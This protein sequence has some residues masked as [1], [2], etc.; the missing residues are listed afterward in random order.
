MD[1]QIAAC[2]HRLS[3]KELAKHF[4]PP[5]KANRLS[6]QPH[7]QTASTTRGEESICACSAQLRFKRGWYLITSVRPEHHS[8]TLHQHV[9]I[10]NHFPRIPSANHSITDIKPIRKV[11]KIELPIVQLSPR[12]SLLVDLLHDLHLSNEDGKR[13]VFQAKIH[14]YNGDANISKK[15]AVD[16]IDIGVEVVGWAACDHNVVHVTKRALSHL[17]QLDEGGESRIW[18]TEINVSHALVVVQL[19]K[20]DGIGDVGVIIFYSWWTTYMSYDWLKQFQ[21]LLRC[22]YRFRAK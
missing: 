9:R 13:L 16:G 7:L 10:T 22:N 5:Q 2:A 18:F 14:K 17:T 12:T 11:T 15:N 20:R 4:I 6:M 8:P 21:S 3:Q 19:V 1:K